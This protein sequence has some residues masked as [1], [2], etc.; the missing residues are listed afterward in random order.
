MVRT[1][2]TG[3]TVFSPLFAEF[4][5]RQ[6][7]PAAKGVIVRRNPRIVQIE[8]QRIDTLSEL[9]FEALC[10][11]FEHREHVCT[12]DELIENIYRQQYSRLAG[13]VTDEALQTLISRLRTRIEPDRKQPRYVITVR[14]EGYKF[15]EPREQ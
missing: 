11:L 6:E 12:K 1:P 10:Y 4:I 13:G 7:A 15:V 9:E 5:R 8:G 14:G 3:I 2:Q